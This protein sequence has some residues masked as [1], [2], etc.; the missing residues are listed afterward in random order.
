[1]NGFGMMVQRNWDEFYRRLCR[2]NRKYVARRRSTAYRLAAW[3]LTIVFFVFSLIA[4]WAAQPEAIT[5]RSNPLVRA[6]RVHSGNEQHQLGPSRQIRGP[7]SLGIGQHAHGHSEASAGL[8]V[9]KDIGARE[10][11]DADR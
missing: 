3:M 1:M 8:L 6:K 9:G 2:K 5:S 7:I 11:W 4:F 10:E